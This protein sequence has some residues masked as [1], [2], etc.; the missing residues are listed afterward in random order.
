MMKIVAMSRINFKAVLDKVIPLEDS[1][2]DTSFHIVNIVGIVHLLNPNEGLCI[3]SLSL[4]L[5][6]MAKFVP[7][8][9]AA[10]ILRTKDTISTTT[11]LAFRSGK[12]VCVGALT[13]YHSLLAC[14]TYR[15]I[16]EKIPGVYRDG[17]KLRTSD[18][19]GRTQFMNW[20]IQNIVAHDDL[21]CRPNLKYISE[22]IPEISNWNPELFPGLKL[23]VWLHPKK[24]CMCKTKKK[25]NSCKCNIRVLLFDT[26][27]YVETGCTDIQSLL[28]GAQSIQNSFADDIYKDQHD[29]DGVNRFEARKQKI[30]ESAYLEF[31]GWRTYKKTTITNTSSNTMDTLFKGLKRKPKKKHVRMIHEEDREENEILAPFLKACKYGQFDN[32][33]FMASY[34]RGAVKDAL[35]YC[36]DNSDIFNKKIMT[37]LMENDF[38]SK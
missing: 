26:G 3:E 14:Q 30:K 37:I 20:G 25:N 7:K 16:I 22:S 11:C 18:L 17:D 1:L 19:S 24:D 4:Y 31:A 33:K 23:L 13:K 36:D 21:H 6:G 28:L 15:Q 12:L 35:N 9:F 8:T 34:D 38:E 2:P 10:A 5:G 27:K 29:D 32:V